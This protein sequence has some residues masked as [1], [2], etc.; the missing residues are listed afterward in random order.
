MALSKPN[1]SMRTIDEES[2]SIFHKIQVEHLLD[3]LSYCSRTDLEVLSATSKYLKGL[4]K[5]KFPSAPYRAFKGPKGEL[6]E[7]LAIPS[8]DGALFG[9]QY[10]EPYGTYKEMLYEFSSKT[11]RPLDL[12]RRNCF[13]SIAQIR[14]YLPD[15]FRAVSVQILISKRVPF[16]V[17]DIPIMESIS[18]VWTDRRMRIFLSFR[19]PNTSDEEL[20]IMNASMDLILSSSTKLFCCLDLWITNLFCLSHRINYQSLY[21]LRMIKIERFH[22]LKCTQFVLD[23]IRDKAMYPESTT[24]LV[25]SLLEPKFS[26]PGSSSRMPEILELME[27]LRSNFS[28]STTPYK[29]CLV[30]SFPAQFRPYSTQINEFREE[31]AQTKEVMLLRKISVNNN[32]ESYTGDIFNL[33][34]ENEVKPPLI[35]VERFSA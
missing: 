11:W 15:D 19:S 14:P 22:F 23:F 13:Y 28:T 31:N 12:I 29:F 33:L 24:I 35:I 9:L 34:K 30:V 21:A 32:N 25:L 8:N 2:S 17:D 7:I 4:I 10:E 6:T 20:E 1:S 5:E 18:H 27:Q 26:R 16:A 3:V